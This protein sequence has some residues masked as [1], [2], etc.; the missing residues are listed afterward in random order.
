MEAFW[1]EPQ[2]SIS[3]AKQKPEQGEINLFF[4]GIFLFLRGGRFQPLANSGF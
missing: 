4:F 2:I 3:F 1:G